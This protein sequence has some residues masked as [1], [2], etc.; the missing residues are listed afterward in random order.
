M[1]Y[2][3]RIFLPSPPNYVTS[4]PGDTWKLQVTSTGLEPT[5]SAI[6][7][8]CSTN[9]AMKTIGWEQVNLLG[10]Q[11]SREGVNEWKKCK[12]NVNALFRAV[13]NWVS[14]VISELLWFMITSLSD[15]FKVF[16]TFFQPIRNETKTNR[17]LRV[18]I[19]PRFVSV[20][21]DWPK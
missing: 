10:S 6:P 13:F 7:V 11:C 5:T 21:F 19:F 15:W 8:Q 1:G 12:K 16:P 20:L 18:H 14:K 2:G 17:G 9:W 3:V 4:S